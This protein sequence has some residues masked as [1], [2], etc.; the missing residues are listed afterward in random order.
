MVLRG[1]YFFS[2]GGVSV[3]DVLNEQSQSLMINFQ[4][5][6]SKTA[7]KFIQIMNQMRWADPGFNVPVHYLQERNGCP[8]T[9]VF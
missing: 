8:L 9:L 5:L 7:F 3:G 2:T 1:L 6:R 4:T